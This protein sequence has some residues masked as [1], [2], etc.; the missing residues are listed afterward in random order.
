VDKFREKFPELQGI[1]ENIKIN[2]FPPSIETTFREK[3]I[4][5]REAS[6]LITRIQNMEG[7]EDVQFNQ[8]WVDRVHSFSRLSKAVGFFLGGILVLASFFIISNVIK[9]NVFARK[10]EIE[11]IR[12]VGAS[13]L[14]SRR[15]HSGS[16]RRD[17]LS[18][19]SIPLD[20]FDPSLS[21]V[22][23]RSAERTDQFPI[24]L[25]LSINHDFS[26]RRHYRFFW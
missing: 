3:S 20:K 10:D 26:R 22:Q 9:L 16:Y 6:T 23:A 2:P 19:P 18:L 25:A 13:P 24:P 12:L 21:G 7:V 14:S 5:F 4:S 15:N 8:E 11:I 1:I 17:S